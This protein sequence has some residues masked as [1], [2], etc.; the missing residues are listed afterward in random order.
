[1]VTHDLLS[2]ISLIP[3]DIKEPI[4]IQWLCDWLGELI[5]NNKSRNRRQEGR[6]FEYEFLQRFREQYALFLMTQT[7]SNYE[8]LSAPIFSAITT[9]PEVAADILQEVLLVEDN[10]HTG[11]KFWSFWKQCAEKAFSRPRQDEKLLLVLLF[12]SIPWK[13]NLHTW[14]PLRNHGDFVRDAIQKVGHT[15]KGFTTVTSMIHTVGQCF[16]PDIVV[17]LDIARQRHQVG[18]IFED[19]NAV[20]SLAWLLQVCVFKHG[21]AIRQREVLRTATLNLLDQLVEAG[22]SLAFRL[23]EMIV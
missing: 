21:T 1:M 9:A 7:T 17:E 10:I 6:E 19:Q 20:V 5:E 4:Y 18:T 22:S 16:L 3:H 15:P 13:E 11:N 2:A 8:L 12:M 23:R 14:E